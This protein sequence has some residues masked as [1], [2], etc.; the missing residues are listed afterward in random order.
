MDVSFLWNGKNT[1]DDAF[2]KYFLELLD[3]G[4]QDKAYW[5]FYGRFAEKICKKIIAKDLKSEYRFEIPRIFEEGLRKVVEKDYPQQKI[6]DKQAI[7]AYIFTVVKHDYIDYIRR[8]EAEKKKFEENEK[9]PKPQIVLFT[10]ELYAD[11]WRSAIEDLRPVCK[12]LIRTVQ[13]AIKVETTLDA[14]KKITLM[15]YNGELKATTAQLVSMTKTEANKQGLAKTFDT[16]KQH[17]RTDTTKNDFETTHAWIRQTFRR[18]G[19]NFIDEFLKNL[20][21]N[22]E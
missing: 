15:S 21:R 22:T 9:K 20:A 12:E 14:T 16:Y 1:D 8:R 13:A 3:A 6:R 18:C 2:V 10:R 19:E 4:E 11:A 17:D 7:Y 5:A